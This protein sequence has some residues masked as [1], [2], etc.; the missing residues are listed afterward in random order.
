MY[1]HDADKMAKQFSKPRTLI[2]RTYSML[3]IIF[4]LWVMMAAAELLIWNNYN[5]Q[6]LGEIQKGF[7]ENRTDISVGTELTDTTQIAFKVTN[8]NKVELKIP[9]SLTN[10]NFMVWPFTKTIVLRN[11]VDTSN[12]ME[13]VL[14]KD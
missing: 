3:V 1:L 2:K 10:L 12:F 4:G 14:N 11:E 9:R 8:D 7:L 6:Y 5:V 13:S